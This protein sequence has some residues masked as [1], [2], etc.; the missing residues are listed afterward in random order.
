MADDLT[1]NIFPEALDE[2]L[3]RRYLAY[4]LS[5]I[6]ARALPDVRD[7]LK[8]VHR[9]LL[10]AMRAL[11]LDP[12]SGFKKCARVVGDVIGQYHPHGDQAVYDAMVRLAQSFAV[13]YP[14]VDGQGNFGNIDG[15]NAAAYR[16]TEAR[17][18]DAAMALMEGL[19]EDAVDFRPT[20]NGESDEPVVMP[21]GYPHLLA[22]GASGIA[23]GM[24]TSIPPHNIGELIDASLYLIKHPNASAQTLRK[25]VPGPDFPTGGAIVDDAETIAEAYALGRGS[26]RVRATWEKEELPRGRY[27]IVVTEIPYQVQKSKLIEKIAD[28]I[29]T[30]KLP[31][32]ADVRDESAEDVRVVLEPKSQNVDPTLLMEGLFRL[33]DLETRFSLNMNV[34]DASGAPRVMSLRETLQA[35]LD[36]RRDVLL[37]RTRFRLGKIA[38]RLE[39]L[40]GY[41]VAYLNLDEVIRIIRYEDEP[42]KELIRTFELTDTQA[43]A[44]LNMRLR[45]LRKLEEMEIKSEHKALKKEQR[46]LKALMKS[47]EAQW[48]R[49]T[50]QLK[51]MKVR[52]G[53]KTE[54]GRRRTQFADAPAAEDVDFEA[55]VEKEPVTVVLSDKGW[56]RTVKGHLESGADLK[57]K[58]GDGEGFLVHAQTTDKLLLFASN[59]KFYTLE[60]KDLPGGRGH[61][62]PLRLLVDL[63]NDE[64]PISAFVYEGGRRFLI[65]ATSGHGFFIAEDQALATTRK[66]KQALNVAAGAEAAVCRPVAEAA[67]R[68]AVIGDNRKLLIFDAEELPEMTRGKGVLLQ[69]YAKGGLSDAA[70]FDAKDGLAWLDRAGRQQTASDWRDW[71]G[72][73]AG[74]GKAPPKG[75]PRANRFGG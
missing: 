25:Y 39:I 30:K 75:F 22:N 58:D 50:G 5:T 8:P 68:V 56:V 48:A 11:K 2:A 24:A 52:F 69:R 6:T 31:I 47:D 60:V 26:F 61:G 16:Y 10:F 62:E 33:S 44:I 20:Y 15:D 13:R 23:V 59:G 4:A 65:A 40:D 63:G 28:L 67:N 55:M 64:I 74:A 37:R 27:Q 17:L 14:L 43:E 35:F 45:S 42:K 38:H 66:G 12:A 7:G 32:L 9:R 19:D 34:L 41:L 18:T 1:E 73:R 72:K 57:Y 36:H 21:A 51:E 70:A 71:E 49:I 54:L 29:Q 53:P 3:G 46:E